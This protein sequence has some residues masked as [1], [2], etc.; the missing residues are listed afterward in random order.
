[1]SKIII[2]TDRLVLREFSLTDAAFVMQL[3]NTNE[4]IKN[5][6][7][8]NVHNIKD[9]ESYIQL[10]MLDNYV[11]HGY[12]MWLVILKESNVPIGM[13]GLIKRDYLDYADVGFALM[14]DFF[15]K[16][17]GTEAAMAC[18]RYG[19]DILNMDCI[20]AIVLPQN[21]ASVRLI[22]KLGMSCLGE[23]INAVSEELLLKYQLIKEKN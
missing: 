23:F 11:K 3:V 7:D 10:A 17:Y 6:G 13:C 16:A 14:P 9:A 1:M 19:F 20:Y 5:I 12:G 22:E 21:I 18:L 4:W 15:K 2:Q 8:R